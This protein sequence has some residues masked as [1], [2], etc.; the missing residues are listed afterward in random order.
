MCSV[1]ALLH[2]SRIA[3]D[4]ALELV[5]A[6]P[7]ARSLVLALDDGTGARD[8]ADGRIARVVQRVVGNL[9]DL[10]VR[11]DAFGVPV[12]YG[13]NLPDA[14][15]L[16]PFD[17]LRVGACQRLLAADAG[18]PRVVGSQRP[19]ERLDLAN[20]ATAVG[21][22]L[23]EVRPFLDGLLRDGDHLGA[24]EPEPVALD[25]AVARLV[26]LLE[27][28][29][30]VELDD[31]DVEAE[32]AEDHVHEHRRLPLPGTRQAHAVAELLVG[33]EQRL[34]GG[35]RLDVR[36]LEPRQGRQGAPPS[37]C[38]RAGRGEASRAG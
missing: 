17:P 35:H 29:L 3:M 37:A 32:L 22:L 23:P 36:K 20:V 10:D 24:L 19:L 6:G 31:R 30:R 21:V 1:I 18:D 33:P 38:R 16:R 8:A 7:A 25:E 4:A 2:E 14:V 9:V 12:D 28:E 34:L 11:L 27:E 15:A 13:L 26:G 5:R